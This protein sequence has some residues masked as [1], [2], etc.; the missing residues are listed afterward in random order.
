MGLG[1]K[2]GIAAVICTVLF[3]ICCIII[4]VQKPEIRS[5]F[6][7]LIYTDQEQAMQ[8]YKEDLENNTST[9]FK[10]A[11]TGSSIIAGAGAIL[12]IISIIKM[13][14]GKEKGIIIPILAIIIIAVFYFIVSLSIM[15]MGALINSA[16]NNLQ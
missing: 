14:K 8:I 5:E 13:V 6:Y 4:M 3:I 9:L 2:I 12:A 10:I 11:N 15:D 7:D 1:K 16:M